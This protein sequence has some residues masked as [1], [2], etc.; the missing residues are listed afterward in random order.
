MRAREHTPHGNQSFAR[1]SQ[2]GEGSQSHRIEESVMC[3]ADRD[4]ETL[5]GLSDL[6]EQRCRAKVKRQH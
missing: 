6:T 3:A 4:S 2:K 1:D 5:E